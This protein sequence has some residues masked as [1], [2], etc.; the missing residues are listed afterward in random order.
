MTF[1]EGILFT[2]Y[3][4]ISK[5]FEIYVAVIISLI[6]A[7][8]IIDVLISLINIGYYWL[9]ATLPSKISKCMARTPT[10]TTPPLA[11]LNVPQTPP[12]FLSGSVRKNSL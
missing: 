5:S 10:T 2:L 8:L 3:K 4:F 1:I 12:P 11:N 7:C 6:F 9:I